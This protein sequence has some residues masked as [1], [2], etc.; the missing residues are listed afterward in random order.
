MKKQVTIPVFVMFCLSSHSQNNTTIKIS[1]A[2]IKEVIDLQGTWI[3]PDTAWRLKFRNA[4]EE[5][6]PIKKLLGMIDK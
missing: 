1:M 2:F 5:N 3:N 4:L 6:F